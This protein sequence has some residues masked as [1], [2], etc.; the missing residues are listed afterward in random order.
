MA[1]VTFSDLACG[2]GRVAIALAGSFREVW[3]I[4]LE[5][6]MI[7][8]GRQLAAQRGVRNIKWMVGKAEDFVASPA[9]FELLTIAEA[10]H[11][12]DQQLVAKQAL[13]WLQPGCCLAIMGCYGIT[14]GAE[15]W[16]R[17]V[18]DIVQQWTNRDSSVAGRPTP[19]SSPDHAELVLRE[20]GFENVASYPFVETH[21]KGSLAICIRPQLVLKKVLGDHWG[22]FEADLKAALFAHDASGN[23]REYEMR[24]HNRQETRHGS[25][26]IEEPVLPPR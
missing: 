15:P 24:I 18:A 19:G 4:D 17:I 11:R 6:E 8:A 12:L 25:G 7:E 1:M 20:T 22:A 3:A 9:S 13:H 26:T 10:F 16:Q 2:P 23:Y 14:S 21:E 5:S